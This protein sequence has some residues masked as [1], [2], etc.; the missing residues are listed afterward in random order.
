MR[1]INL[2]FCRPAVWSRVRR[3]HT[4][5]RHSTARRLTR[6]RRCWNLLPDAWLARARSGSLPT[7][8]PWS[9]SQVTNSPPDATHSCQHCRA[10]LTRLIWSS[11]NCHPSRCQQSIQGHEAAGRFIT[12]LSPPPEPPDQSVAAMGACGSSGRRRRAASYGSAHASNGKLLRPSLL[13][14]PCRDE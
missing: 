4:H 10:A 2:R 9:G 7:S 12:A 5:R 14:L 6:R 8:L 1:R 3:R 13:H 11:F